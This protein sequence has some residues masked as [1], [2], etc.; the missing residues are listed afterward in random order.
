LSGSG[1]PEHGKSIEIKLFT[2]ESA[3]NEVID[4]IRERAHGRKA[5]IAG[6]SLGAQVAV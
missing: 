1:P 3:A 6:L 5:Y 2:M 4:I